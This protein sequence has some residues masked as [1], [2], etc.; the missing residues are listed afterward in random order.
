MSIRYVIR[1]DISW[2]NMMLQPPDT[3][4]LEMQAQDFL[5][6]RIDFDHKKHIYWV[7]IIQLHSDKNWVKVRI[8]MPDGRIATGWQ[9]IALLDICFDGNPYDGRFNLLMHEAT[10]LLQNARKKS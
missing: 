1:R 6:S 2:F 5:F 3:L 7:D 8:Y 10:I 4:H 9:S